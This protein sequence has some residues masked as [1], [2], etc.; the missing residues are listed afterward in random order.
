M[1]FASESEAWDA[2]SLKINLSPRYEWESVALTVPCLHLCRYSCEQAEP[3]ELRLVIAVNPPTLFSDN[4]DP[5]YPECVLIYVR[6]ERG[7]VGSE[8]GDWGS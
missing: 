8:D 3:L 7:G 2:W 6:N 1:C 4:A 5:H